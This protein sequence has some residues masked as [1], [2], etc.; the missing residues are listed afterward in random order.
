MSVA[1]AG[2]RS[3][4]KPRTNCRSAAAPRRSSSNSRVMPAEWR[5]EE[6]NVS[7]PQVASLRG[8]GGRHPLGD[9]GG[10]FLRWNPGEG[11]EHPPPAEIEVPGCGR[12]EASPDP[13]AAPWP[14]LSWGRAQDSR[15]AAPAADPGGFRWADF[16]LRPV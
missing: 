10:R 11:Q 2:L 14:A 9:R 4:A 12:E 5:G 16:N 15:K 8:P 13:G 7:K 6:V 1:S 3:K